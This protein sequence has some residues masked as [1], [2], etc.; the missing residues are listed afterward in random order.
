MNDLMV[1]ALIEYTRANYGTLKIN[2][3]DVLTKIVS[4]NTSDF[5]Y[6]EELL[7]MLKHEQQE[8]KQEV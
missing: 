6:R 2:V 5:K 8:V 3:L 4:D 7:L 1:F